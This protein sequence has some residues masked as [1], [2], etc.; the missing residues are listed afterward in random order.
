M[1]SRMVY[2]VILAISLVTIMVLSGC[3]GCYNSACYGCGNCISDCGNCAMDGA[4][5]MLDGCLSCVEP[6]F[7]GLGI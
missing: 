7:D 5:C 1:K 3:G 6:F 4:D 2:G